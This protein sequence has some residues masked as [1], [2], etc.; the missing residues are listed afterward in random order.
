[1]ARVSGLHIYPFKGCRGIA[2]EAARLTSTGL[3]F[4]RHWVVV[5]PDGKRSS[6][7][8]WNCVW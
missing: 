7:P 6:G 1:M 8:T 2:L 3:A 4:D 5:H